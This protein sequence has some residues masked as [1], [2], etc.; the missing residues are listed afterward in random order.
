MGLAGRLDNAAGVLGELQ[1]IY[2]EARRGE[3]KPYVAGRLTAILKETRAAIE[4]ADLERRLMALELRVGV[5]KK[6]TAQRVQRVE[7]KLGANDYQPLAVEVDRT[8]GY[9]DYAEAQRRSGTFLD[10]LGRP[11]IKIVLCGADADL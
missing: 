10:S 7:D 9:E 4:T 8:I 3:L 1:R 5:R 11:V 2:R 6:P